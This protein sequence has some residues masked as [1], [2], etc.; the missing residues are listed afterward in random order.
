MFDSTPKPTSLK[1]KRPAFAIPKSVLSC[2]TPTFS[3]K[4]PLSSDENEDTKK[5]NEVTHQRKKKK[6]SKKGKKGSIKLK[7][8]DHQELL[9]YLFT[10]KHHREVWKFN[11]TIQKLL[12]KWIYNKEMLPEDKFEIL[13][14]Y[15][16]NLQGQIRSRVYDEAMEK[17][18]SE[19]STD[20]AHHDA[21]VVE[22]AKKVLKVIE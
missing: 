22:R 4:R 8:K 13:L 2:T 5:E 21:W 9:D 18:N 17:G 16:G 6:K 3:L 14:E 20:I 12:I 19:K 7:S 10:W 15:L 11:K 1:K